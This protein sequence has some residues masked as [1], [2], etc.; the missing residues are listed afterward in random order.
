MGL[1]LFMLNAVKRLY[2]LGARGA[3]TFVST[4]FRFQKLPEHLFKYG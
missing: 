3:R 1:L 4:L 2:A